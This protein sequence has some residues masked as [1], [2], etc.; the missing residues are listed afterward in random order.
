MLKI[1]IT[2]EAYKFLS[3]LQAKQYKQVA[4]AVFA[5]LKNPEPHDSQLLKGA[6]QGERRLD[7]GEYRVVYAIA[8]DTVQVLVIGKRNDSDVYK[9]W[10]RIKDR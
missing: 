10:E 4:S 1:A 7:V 8:G 5:L 9:T 3:G 6:K 2:N